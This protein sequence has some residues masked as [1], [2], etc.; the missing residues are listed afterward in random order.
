MIGILGS[1][2]LDLISYCDELP[3][4]GE[5]ILGKKFISSPGGKGANQAL[6]AARA[7]GEVKFY[8]AV[9][10][11]EFAKAAL[12]EFTKEA[13]DLKGIKIVEQTTGIANI[14]VDA[15]G[16]NIIV[17]TSGANATIDKEMAKK[18]IAS[19]NEGDIL[20]LNQEIPFDVILL[21]LKLAKKA[22]IITILNIAP[23][24]RG[25]KQLTALADIIIA[26]QSEFNELVDKEI[27]FEQ[28]QNEIKKH[29]LNNNHTLLVTLGEKGVIYANNKD[30][31]LI[32]APK[33]ISIDSVGAGDCFCGV[34]ATYLD[35]GFSIKQA[36]QRA[37]VGGA[38]AVLKKGAQT[39]FPYKEEI[40]NYKQG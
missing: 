21:V 16:N 24:I 37:V 11:D 3:K 1:I 2:N 28:I 25:T 15:N 10:N 8:G 32:K 30:C 18:T 31:Q 22:K 17:V 14:L 39:S 20:L 29:V 27:S 13:I 9:G 34:L 19:M 7:G 38:L 36:S 33:V 23:I 35:G 40:E 5:T 26:N 12:S 6:A 4:I